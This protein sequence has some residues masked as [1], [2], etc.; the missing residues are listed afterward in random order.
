VFVL[1]TQPVSQAD[2]IDWEKDIR[3]HREWDEKRRLRMN[4]AQSIKNDLDVF[5]ETLEARLDTKISSMGSIIDTKVNALLKI[6]EHQQSLIRRDSDKKASSPVSKS[7][8]AVYKKQNSV[9]P[10]IPDI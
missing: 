10:T 2:A 1:C 9:G 6:I 3:L 7:P 8:H 5:K 4:S